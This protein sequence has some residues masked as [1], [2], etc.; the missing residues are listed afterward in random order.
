MSDDGF[1]FD[2][3]GEDFDADLFFND[4]GEIILAVSVSQKLSWSDKNER[5]TLSLGRPC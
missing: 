1:F 4:D 2:E 5:L 3:E